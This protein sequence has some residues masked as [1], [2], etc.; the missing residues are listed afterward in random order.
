MP[1]GVYK[2]CSS[3]NTT[4]DYLVKP[5]VKTCRAGLRDES[6]L[7]VVEYAVIAGLL[8]AAA[9]VTLGLLG[10]W[11]ADQFDSVGQDVGAGL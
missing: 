7:E 3:T 5:W 2:L 8:V 6:G 10:I 1:H 4:K 9:I 11:V